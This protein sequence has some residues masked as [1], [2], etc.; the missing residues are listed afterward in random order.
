MMTN[1][2]LV[3]IWRERNP[4]SRSFT[5]SSNITHNI[6]CRLDFFLI[7]HH[8]CHSVSNTSQSPGLQSDHAMIFLSY[9]LS[10]EKRGPGYWKLNN[11]LLNDQVY[12]EVISNIILEMCEDPNY[13]NPSSLWESLKFKIRGASIKYSKSKARERCLRESALIDNIARLEHELFVHETEEIR[14][15]LREAQNELLLYYDQKLQGTIIR[16]RAR[17]VEQGERNTRY[18]LNLEKRNK[19]NNTIYKVKRLMGL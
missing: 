9:K 8:L 2:N 19:S 1:Y 11:S 16:S 15:A 14:E 6:Y 17:W 7:S 13:E 18:F 3:D 4:L 5:W 12:I 10:N